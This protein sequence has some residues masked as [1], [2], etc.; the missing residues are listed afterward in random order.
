MR[1]TYASRALCLLL[2]TCQSTGSGGGYAAGYYGRGGRT[3][4]VDL[5]GAAREHTADCYDPV[6]ARRQT[7]GDELME[8]VERAWA[9]RTSRNS[10]DHRAFVRNELSKG[11]LRQGWGYVPKQDLRL[12]R[13]RIEEVG[14]TNLTEEEQEAWGHW[15]MLGTASANPDETMLIGDIV[16]VPNVPEDGVFTLCKITGGYDYAIDPVIHDLGH[17]L[18]VKVLTPGGV[19]NTYE[20]VSSDLRRSLRC[21]SRLWWVGDH[22]ASIEGILAKAEAGQNA[23]FREATD[24]SIRANSSVARQIRVSL[25]GLAEAIE[26]PLR[27][28]LQSAEWEPVLRAAL[29][30]LLRDVEVLH[31][32]GPADRGA[33]LEIHVPNPFDPNEPWVI[34]VQV[35]DYAGQIGADVAEQLEQAIKTRLGVEAQGRLVAVVLASTGAE[36]SVQLDRAMKRLSQQYGVSISCVHGGGLMRVLA[37]GLFM[38]Y[39]DVLTDEN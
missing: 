30:P 35:K 19:A 36:P 23:N 34:A 3:W 10:E 24:H 6:K 13:T 1:P 29:V 11:R 33:D 15:K 32:G 21:R 27:A 8:S 31:T 4:L 37:R 18:P 7:S 12:V 26:G 28:T 22:A 20:G 2:G 25:D 16:L 39:R 9:M 14:W 38:G 5:R 17:M